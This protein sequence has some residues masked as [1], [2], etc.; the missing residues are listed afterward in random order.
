VSWKKDKA[1][2]LLIFNE[3]RELIAVFTTFYFIFSI[4]MNGANL[5][6]PFWLCKNCQT[7]FEFDAGLCLVFTGAGFLKPM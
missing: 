2:V 7:S 3:I 4:Q 5:P 1:V 6:V